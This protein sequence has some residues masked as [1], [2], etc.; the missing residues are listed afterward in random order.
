MAD[1]PL[2]N[3]DALDIGIKQPLKIAI[4]ITSFYGKPCIE[5]R[6]Q[7]ITN[8]DIIKTILTAA[9][10]GQPIELYPTFSDLFRSINTLIE[11][12]IIYYNKDTKE[13]YFTL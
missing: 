2:I 13:Y 6:K 9:M 12:G 5:L 11:K 10:N 4:I 3:D 7:G 1:Q 8:T